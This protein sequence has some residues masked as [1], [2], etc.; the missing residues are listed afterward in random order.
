[1]E[2]NTT[3]VNAPGQICECFISSTR[4]K[5]TMTFKLGSNSTPDVDYPTVQAAKD[6][7]QKFAFRY[8]GE[9]FSWDGFTFEGDTQ[10]IHGQFNASG[11]GTRR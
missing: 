6:A 5:T 1:M 11:H 10:V 7:A 8:G 2:N 3:A 9:K 4:E